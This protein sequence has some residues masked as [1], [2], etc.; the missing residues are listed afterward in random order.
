MKKIY[1]SIL[2]ALVSI[3][4]FGQAPNWEWA[5]G[6]GGTV[7]DKGSRVATDP[8]GNVYIV[9]QFMSPTI[10]FGG[11]TLTNAGGNGGTSDIF[12]AKYDSTGTVLWAKR[13]GGTS[14]DAATSL[15]IDALGNVY[16]TGTFS[17]PILAFGANTLINAGNQ[18]ILLLKYD[19]TG[20]EL[21]ADCA[22]GG[23]D[24]VA[25][26]VTTDALGNIYVTGYFIS[27]FFIVDPIDTLTNTSNGYQDTYLVKY[28]S[29]GNVLWAKSA[30][31]PE[32]A[33][34]IAISSTGDIYVTGRAGNTSLVFDTVNLTTTGTAMYVV[35]FNSVGN[36]LWAKSNDG[37]ASMEGF[38]VA[39][40]VNGSVYV[41]GSWSAAALT[42]DTITLN[43]SG[44]FDIFIVKYDS[45]GNVLWARTE[46]GNG[47]EGSS[48]VV[49]DAANNIYVT[50][51]FGFASSIVFGTTTLVDSGGY[52]LFVLKYDSSGNMLWAKSAGGSG[53]EGG[54][55]L[56]ISSGG[57]IY[58]TGRYT[59]STI[60]FGAAT[61]TNAG[62]NSAD[63]FVAKLL[64]DNNV[65]PGD[66]DNNF[67]V[68]NTDLLPIGLF[69]GQTGLLRA[70][71][72]NIWQPN[73]AADWGQGQPNG[74]NIKHADCNG[75]GTI[76][77]NDTFA[78]NLN[79]NLI[80]AISSEHNYN[81]Q[82]TSASDIYFVT[83]SNTYN[84][85]DM[86]DIEVWAGSNANPVSGL[87]GLAFNINYTASFVQSGTESITYPVSWLGT[88]GID[89]IKI[90]KTD[91]LANTAYCAI[92]RINHTNASGYGKIADF[93]FQVSSS[94]TS[95]SV[96]NLSVS[97]YVA[98]DSVGV[99]IIFNTIKDSLMI[100]VSG[101][102]VSE[103]EN[104]GGVSI[105]PN[106]FSSQTIIT[107]SEEQ[108]NTTIKIM[109]VLGEC[110]LTPPPLRGGR[111]GLIDMSGLAKGVYF[112]SVNSQQGV[113]NRKIVKE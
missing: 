28:D 23:A 81:V 60:S 4:V 16:V 22:G 57:D 95:S 74:F 88:P 104:G 3:N 25:S 101:A 84:P 110:V 83:S 9:G 61:L 109:N 26:Y 75:D 91:A 112:L 37:T 52:D 70:S 76:D 111:E 55:S 93:K 51:G 54:N 18:D 1:I 41:T 29:M 99:P 40:D 46:G 89:A 32:T 87:Y 50:G 53:D 77:S 38:S 79:F 34:S 71:V 106:P 64:G 42:F 43:F 44:M 48:T 19:A 10:V 15:A 49:T 85:G 56:A 12:I 97:N 14:L 17:S 69:Y 31:G 5:K 90:S 62:T 21:W 66:T 98:N 68:D 63:V 35:K 6:A 67:F 103:L 30:V 58:V 96:L 72:S 86:V 92:T 108:K 33:N 65:W 47:N 24:D 8:L 13:A 107:F 11:T 39:V 80:H 7:D 36:V 27:P 100:H 59:G 82:R 113:V 2:I 78:I 94:V 105:Y 20:T 73:Y 45:M 102:G